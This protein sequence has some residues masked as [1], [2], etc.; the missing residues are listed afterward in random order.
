MNK[1]KLLIKILIVI[2]ILISITIVA[3]KI[4][5]KIVEEKKQA[6]F[7]NMHEKF[8]ADMEEIEKEEGKKLKEL[9][10]RSEYFILKNVINQYITD[11]NNF[12]KSQNNAESIIKKLDEEYISFYNINQSNLINLFKE[13]GSDNIFIIDKVYIK[14]I[15]QIVSTYIIY[16]RCIDT[17]TSTVKNDGFIIQKDDGNSS[18]TL[19]LYDYLEEKQLLNLKENDVIDF[20]TRQS[21][22][23]NEYNTFERKLYSEKELVLDYWDRLEKDWKYDKQHLYTMLEE[24]YKQNFNSE[25]EFEEYIN[26]LNINLE[27]KDYSINNTNNSYVCVDLNNNIYTFNRKSILEY[28]IKIDIK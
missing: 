11:V 27:Y 22:E 19:M 21:I 4:G 20:E 9:T 13:Y 18:Y 6:D 26:T 2:A 23:K 17:E 28:T 5:K 7:N 24:E 12:K 1:I 16:G 8:V 25:K 10:S 3:I 15:D 14:D